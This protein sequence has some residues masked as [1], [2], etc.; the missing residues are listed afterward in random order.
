MTRPRVPETEQ[1]IQG[2]AIVGQYDEMQRRLRDKGWLETGDII[3]SGITRGLALE[4][5]PGPGYLGL[6]WL[7]LTRG[8]TLKGVDISADMIALARR[9]A[10]A[11][12]LEGRAEYHHGDGVD[13]PFGPGLFD[14]VF[15]AGSLHEWHE[16]KAVLLEIARVLKPGGKLLIMDFRRDMPLLVKGC[17]WFLARPKS[18]RPG[19]FTSIAAAYT[20]AE[21]R[22]M[23]KEAGFSRCDVKPGMA[24]ITITGCSRMPAIVAPILCADQDLSE[25]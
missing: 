4:I 22:I 12:G 5:G 3:T 24:G 1:G 17:L 15:T 10:A 20:P 9:N 18:M 25:V 19:L 7:R 16:P 11:Y 21:A 13:L 8:T 23:V 6:E 14:A 2:A